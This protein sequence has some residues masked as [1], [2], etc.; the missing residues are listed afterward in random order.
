[1]MKRL[2]LGLTLMILMLSAC[3]TAKTE[4][5][6]VPDGEPFE[7]YLIGDQQ[8]TGKALEE[9]ALDKLPLEQT[10]ILTTED[11]ADYNWEEHNFNLTDEAYQLILFLFA[12][13]LPESGVPFV[14]MSY[15]ERIFAGA[16]WSPISSLSFDGVVILQPLD[17]TSGTLYIDLGYPRPDNFTGEDPRDDPRLEHALEH[18]GLIE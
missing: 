16:F 2:L 15:G 6:I 18:A 17:P 12:A 3:Q 13:G 5:A 1:M 14:I 8:I 7:L 10:P 11:L 9:L 4:D